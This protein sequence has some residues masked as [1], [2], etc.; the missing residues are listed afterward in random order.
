MSKIIKRKRWS[1]ENWYT[2]DSGNVFLENEL[3]EI[4]ND[5]S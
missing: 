4:T 1:N 3:M 2:I 5:I